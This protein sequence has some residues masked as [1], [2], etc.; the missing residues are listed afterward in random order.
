[1]IFGISVCWFIT[2]NFIIDV[3]I[4]FIYKNIFFFLVIASS[5]LVPQ[6]FSMHFFYGKNS[7]FIKIYDF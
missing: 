4:N 1:M 5:L 2:I 7:N 3:R 6:Q